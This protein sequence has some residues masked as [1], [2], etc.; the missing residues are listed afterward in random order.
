[1]ALSLRHESVLERVGDKL[2]DN[3]ADRDRTLDWKLRLIALNP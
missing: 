2:V 1:M 3:E